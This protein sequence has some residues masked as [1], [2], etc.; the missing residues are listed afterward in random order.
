MRKIATI[1]AIIVAIAVALGLVLRTDGV[2]ERVLDLARHLRDTGV[3]GALAFALLAIVATV[4]LAPQA[5]VT[6]PAGFSYGVAAGFAI[7]CVASFASAL[8]ALALG[9]TLLRRRVEQRFRRDRRFRKLDRAVHDRGTLVVVLLRVSPLFPFAPVNYMLAMT[10]VRKR[11]YVAGTALGLLPNTL[12]MV[13][14]GSIAPDALAALRGQ[15]PAWHLA[16]PL[17]VALACAAALALL[18]RRVLHA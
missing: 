2:A 8:V 1:V 7:A 18:A 11:A 15:G 13:Y 16:L 9:R 12:V 4:A 6:V 10:G 14:L 17:A 3:A 5:V